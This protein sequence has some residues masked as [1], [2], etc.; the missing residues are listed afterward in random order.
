MDVPHHWFPLLQCF[1]PLINITIV[2][3][4]IDS[5]HYS[6]PHGWFTLLCC[7]SPLISHHNNVPHHW[8]HIATMFPTIDFTSLQRSPPCSPPLISHHDNVPHHWFHIMTMFPTFD[9]TSLQCSPPSSPPLIS[10]H[11]NVGPLMS[12]HYNV[13]HHVLHHVLHHWFHVMT[14]FPTIDFTSW[15]CSP[16]WFHI[17]TMFP[18]KFS[19]IDFTSWQCSPPCP[20]PLI[21]HHYNVSHHVPNHWFHITSMFPTIDFAS[22]QCSPPCSPPLIHITSGTGRMKRGRTLV[23]VRKKTLIKHLNKTWDLVPVDWEGGITMVVWPLVGRC[24]NYNY[25]WRV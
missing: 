7:S 17:T 24:P 15:Q 22:L 9:F 1:I 25:W 18:I 23:L 10:H 19:A 20:P 2:F 6:V 8:F 14:M 12:H 5:H 13:P 3:P 16:H 11:D 4:T 21:A